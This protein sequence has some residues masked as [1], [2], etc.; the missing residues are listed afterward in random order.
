MNEE[1]I[2]FIVPK[3]IFYN[4]NMRFCRSIS[5]LAV[6]A[7]GRKLE[8]CDAFTASGIRGIRY[9]VENKNVKSVTFIDIDP[10]AIKA[11]KKNAKAAGLR[12]KAVKGNI[13]RLVFDITADF[14]EVDPFGSP[15]PY[16][17]DVMRIF[18]PLKEGYLSLTA[19]D[20]AVLCGAKI[21][22]A[23]KN[24]HSKPLN[25]EFTHETGLR[26]LI[27]KAVEV[28]AEFN[29]GVEPLFSVSDRHYLK[30][31]LKLTRG[32]DAADNSLKQLG[33]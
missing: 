27:K 12:F 23:L 15:S 13:S 17:Y 32:A 28:A 1:G 5:S 10:N 24:Y 18:N 3:G 33:Y 19:T 8:L 2:E 6:G 22:A 7:T 31:V 26:I 9:A 4:P 30:S 29:F 25:N 16:L 11:V 21:K 20:V 14:V